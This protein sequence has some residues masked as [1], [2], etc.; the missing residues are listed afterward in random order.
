MVIDV[1]DLVEA[2]KVWNL[3]EAV[4][5]MLETLFKV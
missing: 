4:E 5:M 3:V 2:S 1:G